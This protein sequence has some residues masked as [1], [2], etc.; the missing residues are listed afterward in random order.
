VA[1]R[2]D[3]GAAALRSDLE[4]DR[5]RLIQGLDAVARQARLRA[6]EARSGR[7]VTGDVTR[8]VTALTEALRLSARLDATT[9][10]LRALGEKETP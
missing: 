8:M 2:R 9:E 10:A 6:D 1:P 7:P 3:L 5:A 4:T